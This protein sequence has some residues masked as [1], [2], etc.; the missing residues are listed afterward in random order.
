MMKFLLWVFLPV[1]LGGCIYVNVPLNPGIQRV[2]EE[3]VGG[4][5]DKKILIT[6]ISG[7]LATGP[8][9]LERFRKG[10]ALLPRLR[11][12]LDKALADPDIVALVVRIDSPGGSVTASDIIYHELTRFRE[13]K[14]VPVIACVMDMAVSGGYYAAMAADEV[15][16]HPTALVGGVGVISFHVALEDLL[17]KVGVDVAT[18]Q[19]GPLKDFWSPLRPPQEQ[20]LAIMQGI[21]DRLHQ[22]FMGIVEKRRSLKSCVAAQVATGQVFDAVPARD[23]GLVDRVGY[24]DDAVQRAREMAGVDTARQIIY[25]RPGRYAESI[26][27]GQLP[28]LRTLT[29]IESGVNEA[30]SPTLRYQY[31]P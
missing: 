7:I 11:E 9:G 28:L 19:S 16:A 21:T 12:E 10:P 13:D 14:K 2:E 17:A 5:G 15:M 6:D 24:L 30:L 20:E 1:L 29:D 25:R 27:A 8:I 23:L 22:R 4:A 3:T 18:V 26:Y 31:I